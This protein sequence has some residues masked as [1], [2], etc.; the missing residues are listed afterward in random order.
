MIFAKNKIIFGEI[1]N[2][3]GNFITSVNIVS[4]PLTIEPD[5]LPNIQN[6]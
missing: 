1:K 5:F 6:N 3:E 4:M 2:E